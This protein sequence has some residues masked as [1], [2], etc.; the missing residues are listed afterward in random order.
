MHTYKIL[1]LG[2]LIGSAFIASAQVSNDAISAFRNQMH[3]EAINVAVP[4]TVE[5]PLSAVDE[6]RNFLIIDDATQKT[7]PW[8]LNEQYTIK[9]VPLTG[10]M[11][12]NNMPH[13]TPDVLVDGNLESGLAFN[14]PEDK[15]GSAEIWL[16]SEVP[17]LSSGITF[18]FGQNVTLPKTIEVRAIVDGILSI[19]LA[20]TAF[21]KEKI[22]F[23]PTNSHYWIVT[24]RYEQPMVINE[25]TLSQDNVARA[26]TS[27]LRFLAQPGSTYTVYHNPDRTV[28]IPFVEQGNLRTDMNVLRLSAVTSVA[29][30]AYSP[31]DSDMDGVLD[32][33]DNCVS[34]SNA[35]QV[36]INK[37]GQGDACE[38]FDQDG[39]VNTE[40][41]C[42]NIPNLNQED[43]DGDGTGDVCDAEESR[44]TEKYT[45]VPWA[46]MGIALLVLCI[47]FVLVIQ[48]P[49]K[50]Q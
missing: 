30:P 16:T 17:F 36:D 46:G 47:L 27:G 11:K 42:T 20:E 29:N 38:D 8:F 31:A 23:I 26:V 21:T 39:R 22:Q 10:A 15:Q 35:E 19:V 2:I 25:V 50:T 44:I 43:T 48:T 7:V 41:N 6:Y 33:V 5:L 37:N 3:I 24:L 13:L 32:A 28:N 4:T 34:I 40:D 9:P 18:D 45:W 14:L 1:G 12:L 49:R